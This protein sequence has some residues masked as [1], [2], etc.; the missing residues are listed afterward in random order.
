VLNKLCYSIVQ[1]DYIRVDLVKPD[2]T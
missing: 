2:F 1:Y